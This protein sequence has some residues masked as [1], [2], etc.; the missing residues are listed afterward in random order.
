ML[1][2][3]GDRWHNHIAGWSEWGVRWMGFFDE[4]RLRARHVVGPAFG[5]CAVCYFAFHTVSGERGLVAWRRLQAEVAA[6]QV[7][8]ASIQGEREVLERRVHLL[9]P[10]GVDRDMLDEASRRALNFG[11]PDEAVITLEANHQK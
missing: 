3:N 11:Q 7:D 4:F 8:V 2:H 5:I 6:A 10:S 1:D 9:S